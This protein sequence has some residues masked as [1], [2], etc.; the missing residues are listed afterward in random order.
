MTQ[1]KT[2]AHNA[3]VADFINA[4]DPKK[5]ADSFALIEMMERLSG[6]KATMWGPSIIGFGTCQYKLTSGRT[7]D[8]CRIGFSPRKEKFSLYVL[9]CEGD[10]EAEMQLVDKLGKIKMG[11]SCIYFK[12]LEDLNLPVL[13]QLITTSLQNTKKKWG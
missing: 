10:N 13:E 5:A 11:T 4:A 12:K 2:R 8:M 6:E 7:G 3:S 9:N 1:N